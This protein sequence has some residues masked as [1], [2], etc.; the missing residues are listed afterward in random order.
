MIE[1]WARG[2]Q[3]PM[4]WT[5]DQVEAVTTDTLVMLPLG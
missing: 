1:M 5:R 3:A 2:E 4:P